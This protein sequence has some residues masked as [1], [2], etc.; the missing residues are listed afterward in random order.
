MTIGTRVVVGHHP[1]LANGADG[2]LELGFGD[3]DPDERH[4]DLLDETARV[5]PP[6][7]MR[8]HGPRNQSRLSA[9]EWRDVPAG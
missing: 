5:G 8:A 2:E 6:C 9:K 7:R 3:I 1:G 4:A